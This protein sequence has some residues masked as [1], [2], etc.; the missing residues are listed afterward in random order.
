[1]IDAFLYTFNITSNT[2]NFKFLHPFVKFLQRKWQLP[3]LHEDHIVS[4]SSSSNSSVPNLFSKEQSTGLK[5]LLVSSLIQIW[6]ICRSWLKQMANKYEKQDD[7][8]DWVSG[9]LRKWINLFA[10]RTTLRFHKCQYNFFKICNCHF[11]V[12]KN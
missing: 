2:K 3:L 9:E 4:M 5:E 11:F 1:V 6:V 7:A 10:H 8:M 12:V